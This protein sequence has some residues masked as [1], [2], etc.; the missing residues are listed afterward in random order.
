MVVK[1]DDLRDLQVEEL[2]GLLNEGLNKLYKDDIGLISRGGMEQSISF[3]Y[4]IYLNDL[5]KKV[6]WL[7]E[8]DLDI[9]YGKNGGEAK[10]TPRKPKGTRPDIILHKREFNCSNILVIELKGW[11]NKTSRKNDII[12]L[13]D[14]THNDYGYKFRL[15]VLLDLRETSCEPKYYVNGS[16]FN[17]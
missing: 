7:K 12:K 13:E 16:E 9:E 15:G 1:A 14:F 3:R 8:L 5:F 4:A 11:W 10:S 17:G 2:K 6:C